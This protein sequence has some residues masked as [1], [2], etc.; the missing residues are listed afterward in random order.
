VVERLRPAAT[1]SLV[2][3][4]VGLPVGFLCILAK[5]R[6]SIFKDQSMRVAGQGDTEATN[7]YFH[8]RTRYQEL[9]RYLTVPV[10]VADINCRTVTHTSLLM[11]LSRAVQ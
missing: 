11:A 4:T 8:I 7:P 10:T 6:R 3:Y 5:H 9:Y 1:L 2:C